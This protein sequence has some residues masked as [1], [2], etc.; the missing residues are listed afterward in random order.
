MS[1][2]SKIEWCEVTWN[3]T[4]GCDR[5]SDGCDHCLAPETLVLRAD[6]TWIPISDIQV[7][8][9]LVGFTDQPA[10]GQ[11]RRW[12]PSQVLATWETVKPTVEVELAN[13]VTIV[14]SEDHRWLLANRG[15]DKWWRKT[16]GLNFTNSLRT[17]RCEPTNTTTPEYRRG[18]VAGATE[19]DGT[20]RWPGTDGQQV[21]WR[22]AKP[23]RDRVV[24]DR[25]ERFLA[26]LS[27]DVSVRP[28]DNGPNN[29]GAA[30]PLP[31]LKVETRRQHNLTAITD[32]LTE[33]PSREWMAGWLAGMFDTDASYTGGN[34]RYCQSKPNGVLDRVVQYAKEIGFDV[35]REDWD[36]NCPSAR[37]KGGIAENIAFLSAISPALTRRCEDF[38][39]R[40][41]ETADHAVTGV[42]RGPERKLID[43]TTSTGTF[44]AEGALT[45][46][47]YA[48]TLAKRLKGM[49]S[50][51]Y[52]NDG[53]PRTSGPG[54]AATAHE[55]ALLE[56][57]SWR[58]P[59]TVFV[60]SMSDLFHDK[61]P[62]EFIARVFAVMALTP[63]HTY[64]VLTK[65][66]GRMRSLL[67]SKAFV[68]LW[69]SRL[70]D[71]AVNQAPRGMEWDGTWSYPLRNAW[72]GVSV[73]S[74]RW[75]NSRIP[76]LLDT[77]AAVRFLSCEPLLGPVDL[78]GDVEQ[79]GP[80]VVCTGCSISTDYGT[81]VEYD[82]DRQVG[83]DWVIVGGESGPGAR[84]MH[85]DWSRSLRDQCTAA[86]VAFH[87]KQFGAWAP[88]EPD[89][90]QDRRESDRIIRRDGY[91]WQLAEPH[92]AED[93]TEVTV[94]RVGKHAAGR[95]L[96]G[97]TWDEYPTVAS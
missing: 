27:V 94:R 31:M 84:P 18:Y 87:F 90:G 67:N 17:V 86:G 72:L 16:V 55:D 82:V 26:S 69:S 29:F 38:Y 57:L 24:L 70:L 85:P 75:A 59:R 6:M 52:Q 35:R 47:C 74:Q 62:D 42:R 12:E 58:K 21:Y 53:D 95:V 97:R 48:M 14:A 43:I 32:M 45:H 63:R 11:N 78:L 5:V 79:P 41:V 19:G 88:V 25:L 56:P 8:D 50:A 3:P 7:G 77:P 34:L 4:T 89:A 23:E 49:G 93:G 28:F 20:L 81:G 13:G 36:H 30:N 1:T 46:N 10:V 96:D 15:N 2:N 33:E 66:H 65:R 54:F 80:A 22:V 37:L 44:I 71:I 39:G 91:T 64:Q 73:E 68:D 76:A 83:V 61:I 9:T 60:N 92:G 51:K 40:N